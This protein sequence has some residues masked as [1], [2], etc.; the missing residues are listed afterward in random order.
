[1]SVRVSHGARVRIVAV[2]SLAL[3]W[4]ATASGQVT[5]TVERATS[6]ADSPTVVKVLAE[7]CTDVGA[8]DL[9]VR[10][11]PE[12]VRFESVETGTAAANGMLDFK[13]AEPGR[14]VVSLVD[15]DGLAGDGDLLLLNFQ[16]IGEVGAKSAVVLEDV[17]A[18]HVSKYV[19]I[20]VVI[21][22]SELVVALPMLDQPPP[23]APEERPLEVFGFPLSWVITAGAVLVM[24]LM[25]AFNMGKRTHA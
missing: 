22:N 4:T 24:L 6:F 9:T 8:L 3:L 20:P 1:M 16:T 19:E 5:F 15:A 14:V 7:D 2:L 25:I 11:D 18:N 13:S 10:F 21:K 12:I 23:D 17:S